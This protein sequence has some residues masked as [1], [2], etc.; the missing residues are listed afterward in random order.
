MKNK[1]LT[2]FMICFLSIIVIALIIFLTLSLINKNFLKGFSFKTNVSN[3]KVIDKVYEEVV[4]KI[5]IDV[6]SGQL[7]IKNGND[8]EMHIVIYG[9]NDRN[10]VDLR[11]NELVI[12]SSEK[13]CVGICFNQTISKV[14][15]YL[16]MDYEGNINI[17][18]NYGDIKIEQFDNATIDASMSAGDIVTDSL[19]VAKIMNKYGDI[20]ING[21]VKKISVEE[22]CGDVLI[23]NADNI[24]VV[25]NFGDIKINKV[26]KYLD[27]KDDC[28]DIKIG[29]L[30]IT[31]DSNIE[32]D[33]GDIEIGSTNEIFINAKT[34]LGDTKIN[35]N[36]NKS[37]VTLKINNSLG[38]IRV[39][40]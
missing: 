15:V 2:I 16:P 26:N 10:S 6:K 4:G 25:N 17:N 36:Y 23:N 20:T 28:G 31:E 3:N 37:D 30:N 27:V 5:R 1:K 9:D 14:E 21:Y 34:S 22:K 19:N 35:N 13:S 11:N 7:E 8:N 12:T 18:S 33:F 32:N 40:N 38:D 39:K 24:E 29:I